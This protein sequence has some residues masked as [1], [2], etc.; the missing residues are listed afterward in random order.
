MEEEA[1]LAFL[2]IKYVFNKEIE[3]IDNYY[4]SG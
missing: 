4:N 2:I 3:L 1:N